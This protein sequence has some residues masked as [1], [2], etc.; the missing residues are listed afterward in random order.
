MALSKWTSCH[1]NW[2]FEVAIITVKK[3]RLESSNLLSSTV[4][5]M[6][7]WSLNLLCLVKN[8]ALSKGTSRILKLEILQIENLLFATHVTKLKS[9]YNNGKK[10]GAFKTKWTPSPKLEIRGCYNNGKN[11]A[12]KVRT[13]YVQ[14]MV[15]KIE[16]SK[17]TTNVRS[18]RQNWKFE[19]ATITQAITVKNWCPESLNLLPSFIK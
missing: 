6:A 15:K 7:P 5:K 13:C 4:K 14:P 16:L 18:P 19:V 2:K 3:W 12:L 9:C 1:Q 17:R 10:N 11:G 8:M